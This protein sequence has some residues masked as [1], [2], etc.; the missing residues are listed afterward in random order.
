MMGERDC[1]AVRIF[2]KQFCDGIEKLIDF[3]GL[4]QNTIGVLTHG[5]FDER[6]IRGAGR[7]NDGGVWRFGFDRFY[8]F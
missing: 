4:F 7:Y 3:K 1:F 2:V 5:F 6:E 8:Q